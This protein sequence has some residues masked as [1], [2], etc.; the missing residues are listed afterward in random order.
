MTAPFATG[1]TPITATT[2]RLVLI[3]GDLILYSTLSATEREENPEDDVWHISNDLKEFRRSVR[4]QLDGIMKELGGTLVVCLSDPAANFRKALYP[5]YKEN[6]RNVRKPVG[7]KPARAWFAEKYDAVTKPGLEADD[8]MGILATKPGNDDAVIVSMD[9]DMRSIP[10]KLY[11]WRTQDK[12]TV[13][14]EEAELFWLYQTLA[15]DPSDNYPGCPGVGMK[16]AEKLL[17]KPGDKW[18][19]VRGA[20]SA[21][22]LSEDEAITQ[23]RLARI[24]RWSDW[25]SERQ[26]PILWTPRPGQCSGH[27]ADAADVAGDAAGKPA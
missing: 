11:R 19:I 26:Q 10:A 12:I 21:A 8:V 13:S 9:K 1:A 17:A 16:T 4:A 24:L 5:P 15:G 2:D 6:R 20:F 7:F 14:P 27:P 18:E 23:A 3:D 25:N 22:G